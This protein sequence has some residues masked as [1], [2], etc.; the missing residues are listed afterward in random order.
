MN[1]DTTWK[2]YVN[3]NEPPFSKLTKSQIKYV[4]AMVNNPNFKKQDG[5]T[6]C[7]VQPNTVYK[8]S[9]EVDESIKLARLASLKQSLDVNQDEIIRQQQLA[10]LEHAI[11]IRANREILSR[12]DFMP[13]A[14]T[15]SELIK[16]TVKIYRSYR[17]GMERIVSFNDDDRIASKHER[18]AILERDNFTCIYCGVTPMDDNIELHVDHIIPY[19]QGGKT[20]PSNLATACE[21]CNSGKTDRILNRDILERVL[22]TVQKRNIEHGLTDE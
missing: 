15:D 17:A 11:L 14:F 18:W 19:A 20:V 9:N 8:W 4:E 7:G 6:Y 3:F 12:L 2:N 13:E 16:L 5:A 21:P 1:N 22:K 10:S